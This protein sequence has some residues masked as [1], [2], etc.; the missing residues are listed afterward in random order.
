[1]LGVGSQ[2]GAAAVPVADIGIGAVDECLKDR[3]LAGFHFIGCALPVN[4]AVFHE[5]DAIGNTEDT[6][7]FM[8]DDDIGDIVFDLE[9][10]DEF[11][12]GIGC[13]GVKSGV[14][15]IVA[16]AGGVI[17]DGSGKSDPFFHS[18]GKRGGHGV[19][20]AGEVDD[21][22]SFFDFGI[23]LCV[24]GDAGFYER[25]CDILSD[26]HG[27]KKRSILKHN[28]ELFA[29]RAEFTFAHVGDFDPVDLDT[30]FGGAHEP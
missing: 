2:G 25:E 20:L 7:E 1:V 21:F 24:I 9:A 6:A 12:D 4:F 28:T 18:S 11:V 23:E 27:I 17:D 14:R 29:D 10:L 30:A 5:N 13:D 15:F 19:F 8:G 16:D 3:V 26:R 22:E